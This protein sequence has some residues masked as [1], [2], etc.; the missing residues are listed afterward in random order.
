MS[1]SISELVQKIHA[2]PSRFFLAV[3]GGGTGAIKELAETPGA[4]RTLLEAVV[5]YSAES[6]VALLGGNPDQYCS[7][8]TA[9]RMAMAGFLRAVRLDKSDAPLAGIACT[10]SLAT[11]RPKRGSHRAHIAIQ[12]LSFTATRS[13]ELEKG[14]R[15]REEEGELVARVMVSA[16]AEACGLDPSLEFDLRNEETLIRSQTIAPPTW[17]EL[18]LG[19]KDVLLGAA[20]PDMSQ[21]HDRV[22]FSGAFN[23][24]HDGHWGMA[25]EASRILERPVDFELSIL[26][27]DK[28]PIDFHE[29][30][31][32]L[33][34]F[35][36]GK[37]VWLTRA[38]TFVE[39]SKLFPGA[40][41]IVG[42]DT[43]RRIA[44]PRYYGDDRAACDAALEGIASRGC[45]FLVFGRNMG[46]TGY[47]SLRQLFLPEVLRNIC[48]EVPQE[49]FR[50]DISSTDLR[51]KQRLESER[52]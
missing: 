41:F 3:S 39:K 9:R 7:A 20:V 1:L 43:L 2:S 48:R 26:N 18:L 22:I 27:P 25:E 11:D 35:G 34:Q 50:K 42:T 47:V 46:G 23:P 6:M 13:L 37:S 44:E 31:W 8:R 33:D 19:K 16:V 5:P 36:E 38:S 30:R 40:T 10:A 12:T 17:Q 21:L 32:R 45:R 52:Q 24:I 28:P 14:L 15:S 49:D 29:M 51:R 4:S